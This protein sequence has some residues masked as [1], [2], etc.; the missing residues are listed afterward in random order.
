MK[1]II[2]ALALLAAAGL[3]IAGCG[4]DDDDD[5]TNNGGTSGTGASTNGGEP[6]SS[7][8]GEGTVAGAPGTGNVSCDPTVEGVCQNATD[9]PGVESGE[10]RLAAGICGKGECLGKDSQCSIDC[11]Q[12][13]VDVTSECADCYG[14]AVAC[15]A[16]NCLG[17]CIN[18]PE[19]DMCKAC[20]VTQGC[21]EAFNTC[22]GL[23]E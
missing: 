7:N 10:V 8:G 6:S 2:S 17:E 18:D 22:S 4:G 1:R 9:C 14:A 13:A 11:I 3:G 20:Q 5:T 19:A 16:M 15:T 21:R 12:E 23:P